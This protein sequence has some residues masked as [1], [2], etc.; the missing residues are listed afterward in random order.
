MRVVSWGAE[1]GAVG[2]E[3]PCLTLSYRSTTHKTASRSFLARQTH[4]ET[5]FIFF[6]P[7]KGVRILLGELLG[8]LHSP[9]DEVSTCTKCE[10]HEEVSEKPQKSDEVDVLLHLCGSLFYDGFLQ[11]GTAERE[12]DTAV[13]RIVRWGE[14]K[15]KNNK[16]TKMKTKIWNSVKCIP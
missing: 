12:R 7:P 5:N 15:K 10:E 8:S 14:K 2:R 13:R 11:P 1:R 3:H 4:A 16:G 9:K 6:P